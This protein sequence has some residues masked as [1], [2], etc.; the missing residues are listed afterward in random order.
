MQIRYDFSQIGEKKILKKISP[1]KGSLDLDLAYIYNKD[2]NITFSI[3]VCCI[4]IDI[5][6]WKKSSDLFLKNGLELSLVA[7]N[8]VYNYFLKKKIYGYDPKLKMILAI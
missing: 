3:I 6:G 2:S 7:K 8:I 4:L 1:D 5:L